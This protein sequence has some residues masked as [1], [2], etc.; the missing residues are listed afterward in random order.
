MPGPGGGPEFQEGNGMQGWGPGRMFEPEWVAKAGMLGAPQ[1]LLAARSPREQKPSSA[2][3]TAPS[4]GAWDPAGRAGSG[5]GAGL[6][7]SAIT[8][9]VCG[10]T[11]TELPSSLG[12]GCYWPQAPANE[13]A[14]RPAAATRWRCPPLS[15]RTAPSAPG[16]KTKAGS[17]GRC[18]GK[19]AGLLG[20]LDATV[21]GGDV[22]PRALRGWPSLCVSPLPR[23]PLGNLQL[24]F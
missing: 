4:C 2:L 13:W 17:G 23:V 14:P 21:Q 5:H 15:A 10:P 22:L 19:R 18:R 1:A 12:C 8:P 24:S 9:A 3:R 7:D 16:L 6:S 20:S 11:A